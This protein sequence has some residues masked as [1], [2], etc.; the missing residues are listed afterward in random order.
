MASVSTVKY[1]EPGSSVRVSD[2]STSDSDTESNKASSDSGN[3]PAAEFNGSMSSM[4]NAFIATT[5]LPLSPSE[6]ESG[7]ESFSLSTD[8]DEPVSGDQSSNMALCSP[9]IRSEQREDAKGHREEVELY[10]QCCPLL[11]PLNPKKQYIGI[12]SQTP[13]LKPPPLSMYFHLSQKF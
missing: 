6:S 4:G 9:I 11:W 13:P 12:K 3:V 7:D 2:Q 5:T 1:D 8:D 10:L